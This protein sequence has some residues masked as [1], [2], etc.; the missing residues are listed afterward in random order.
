MAYRLP[1]QPYPDTDPN[2][3][4]PPGYTADLQYQQDYTQQ[5]LSYEPFNYPMIPYGEPP[6]TAD[7][8]GDFPRRDGWDDYSREYPPRQPPLD[9]DDGKLKTTTGPDATDP[10]MSIDARGYRDPNFER[11]RESWA[12]RNAEH[13]SSPSFKRDADDRPP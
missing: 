6:F 9:Y 3:S 11:P 8:R 2:Q 4:Y 10:E 5:A 13:D 12:E 1:N 7:Y